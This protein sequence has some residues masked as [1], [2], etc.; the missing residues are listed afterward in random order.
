MP[1]SPRRVARCFGLWFT[2]IQVHIAGQPQC[3]WDIGNDSYF[4]LPQM[5]HTIN[6]L[7]APRSG[8]GPI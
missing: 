6:R 7:S 2:T 5:R 1:F 3:G 8:H 4:G